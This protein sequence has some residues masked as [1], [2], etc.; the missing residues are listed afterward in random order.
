M[1]NIEADQFG[2]PGNPN[3]KVSGAQL[4]DELDSYRADRDAGK[5]PDTR[6]QLD[7]K[8]PTVPQACFRTQLETKPQ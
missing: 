4:R 2:Q 1:I 7:S 8:P 5:L 6:R 3:D